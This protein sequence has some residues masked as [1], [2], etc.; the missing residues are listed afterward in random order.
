ME[1]QQAKANPV[2]YWTLVADSIVS[3]T[4]AL[5]KLVGVIVGKW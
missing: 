2:L 3:Q 1:G 5:S 4:P